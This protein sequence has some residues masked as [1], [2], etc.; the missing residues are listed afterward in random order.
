MNFIVKIHKT[1]HSIQE[2]NST[3]TLALR[4]I[5]LDLLY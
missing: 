1:A 2:N 4:N 5:L 3:F